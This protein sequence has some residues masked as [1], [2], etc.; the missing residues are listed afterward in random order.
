MTDNNGDSLIKKYTPVIML[1][2]AFITCYLSFT[3]YDFMLNEITQSFENTAK[4]LVIAIGSS[5]LIWLAWSWFFWAIERCNTRNALIAIVTLSF[6]CQLAI[7]KVSTEPNTVGSGGEK[8]L[9]VQTHS[10]VERAESLMANVE[11]ANYSLLSLAHEIELHETEF[12]ALGEDEFKN[13]TETGSPGHGAVAD[14][15]LAVADRLKALMLQLSKASEQN[16]KLFVEARKLLERMRLA[17]KTT[18]DP[19][20]AIEK[21][22]PYA[23]Q[24]SAIMLKIEQRDIAG[25]ISRSMTI[26]PRQIDS[27]ERYSRNPQLR[28]RQQEIIASIRASLDDTI[29]MITMHLKGLE[30]LKTDASFTLE[31]ITAQEGVY[32]H[33]WAIGSIWAAN[34]V[35]D[36]L[37]WFLMLIR[38]V[39]LHWIKVSDRTSI[40]IRKMHVGTLL[41]AIL[42]LS[43][44]DNRL[45]PL[46]QIKQLLEDHFGKP[47]LPS[48]RE[49][50]DDK[51]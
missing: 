21:M 24:F 35:I 32:K 29:S 15:R 47:H 27:R 26:L 51:V 18:P 7:T 2:V 36:W 34:L 22:A 6:T 44:L 38:I 4:A 20:E 11:K 9:I 31:R 50:N 3:G 42:A 10:E 30:T 23:S 13:G 8:V 33:F 41:D 14:S 12:R 1:L 17:I 19:R 37:I 25:M 43:S 46:E 28:K 5:L 49:N 40:R 45:P 48:A 16:E 39:E